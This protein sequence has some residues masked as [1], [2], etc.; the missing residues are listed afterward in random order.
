[1]E[2]KKTFSML[3]MIF[4]AF[5]LLG[6]TGAKAPVDEGAALPESTSL[7]AAEQ[8]TIAD[9]AQVY[10]TMYFTRCTHSVSR[11]TQV[12][13]AIRG[14]SFEDIR[15]YY[16]E[17]N[18]L[19]LSKERVEMDRQI[20]LYCP[21]HKVISMDYSGQVVLSENRYG[22]GM[23]ILKVYEGYVPEEKVKEQLIAGQGFDTEEE[24]EKWLEENGRMP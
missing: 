1:M 15:A 9:N 18:I 12:A 21:M 17:W 22:D 24:A 8:E 7:P 16:D 14:A 23:A 10:Q 4:V 13:D 5:V 19:S 2:N 11:R 6:V 20:E 3:A